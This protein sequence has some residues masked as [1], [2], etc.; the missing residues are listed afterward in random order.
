MNGGERRSDQQRGGD[1]R[2]HIVAAAAIVTGHGLANNSWQ[3]F[4]SVGCMFQWCGSGDVLYNDIVVFVVAV[5]GAVATVGHTIA[6]A[7]TK[8]VDYVTRGRDEADHGRSGST[9][10]VLYTGRR[11][12]V[13]KVRVEVRAR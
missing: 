11:A 2:T 5:F 3:V 6:A 10:P 9:V 1:C 4:S 13:Y 8:A 12:T 7:A